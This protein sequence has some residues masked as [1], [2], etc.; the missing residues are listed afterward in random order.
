MTAQASNAHLIIREGGNVLARRPCG[1]V[2]HAEAVD[3]ANSLLKRLRVTG[4]DV[5][6]WV[7]RRKLAEQVMREVLG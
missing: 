3:R 7:M 6:A 5:A 1:P 4:D 2:S